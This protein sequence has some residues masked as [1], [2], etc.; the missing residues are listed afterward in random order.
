LRGGF[1]GRRLDDFAGVF[2]LGHLRGVWNLYCE[3]LDIFG[4]DF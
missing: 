3:F 2:D 1:G 4:I